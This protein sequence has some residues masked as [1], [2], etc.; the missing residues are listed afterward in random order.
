MTGNLSTPYSV[1]SKQNVST[2]ELLQRKGEGKTKDRKG[3]G[4]I[5]GQIGFFSCAMSLGTLL[6]TIFHLADKSMFVFVMVNKALKNFAISVHNVITPLMS[7]LFPTNFNTQVLRW[8]LHRSL[9]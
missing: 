2:P 5:Q 6:F 7:S 4:A 1:H 8:A 3:K 9:F